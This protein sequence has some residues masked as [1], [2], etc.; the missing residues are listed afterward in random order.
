MKP[1]AL[2]FSPALSPLNE[3]EGVF[4]R[5]FRWAGSKSTFQNRSLLACVGLPHRILDSASVQR[6]TFSVVLCFFISSSLFFFFPSTLAPH[7]ERP[8]R[9]TTTLKD[10]RKVTLSFF[11]VLSIFVLPW[12]TFAICIIASFLQKSNGTSTVIGSLAPGWNGHGLGLGTTKNMGKPSQLFF[13]FVGEGTL[14][15]AVAYSSTAALCK[16]LF[17]QIVTLPVPL[18][19]LT[20]LTSSPPLLLSVAHYTRLVSF[21]GKSHT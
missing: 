19:L 6:V 13:F 8:V 4:K 3:E 16:A 14:T 12:L 15:F 18:I 10:K 2:P 20:P 5:R 11:S 7:Y 17:L 1:C 21:H 9:Y